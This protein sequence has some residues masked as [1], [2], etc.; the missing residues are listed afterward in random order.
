MICS[1]KKAGEGRGKNNLHEA[2]HATEIP[3]NS[4]QVV[5]VENF[6]SRVHVVLQLVRGRVLLAAV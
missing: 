5:V 1:L 2:K 6:P 3:P 4:V